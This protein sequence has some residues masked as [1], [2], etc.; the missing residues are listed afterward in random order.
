MPSSK[1]KKA[2]KKTK[3]G[4]EPV[5]IV[6]PD[7]NMTTDEIVDALMAVIGPQIVEAIVAQA[8]PKKKSKKP[9]KPRR[10]KPA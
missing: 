5:F 1:K 8:R 3:A 4:R 2:K 9:S 6:R 7:E 10:R